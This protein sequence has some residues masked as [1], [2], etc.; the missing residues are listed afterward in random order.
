M[1]KADLSDFFHSIDEIQVNSFFVSLGYPK[2]ISFEMSRICTRV[3]SR[4]DQSSSTRD[5]SINKYQPMRLGVL[6]Q[7]A[8]TS[9]CLANRVLLDVDSELEELA[10]S[11]QLVYTRYAD[12]IVLSGRT[13]F[14][15][16]AA[17]QV[18]VSL[19]SIVERSGYKLNEAKTKIVGPGSAKYVLGLLVLDDHVALPR[20][21]KRTIER[22]LHGS[23]KYGVADYARSAGFVSVLGFIN[24]V[25][26]KLA[27]A[28][29]IDH[30][31]SSHCNERWLAIIRPKPKNTL[32][33]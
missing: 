24:H 8:P 16:A 18:F 14:D 13:N 31:W 21:F 10:T 33:H 12:D 6:P 15:R 4:S 2:L 22:S 27:F 3:L 7:G 19:R 32:V 5:Y 1:I 28:S 17:H 29:S 20:A 9:G 11:N 30:E 23:E 26:G 25:S